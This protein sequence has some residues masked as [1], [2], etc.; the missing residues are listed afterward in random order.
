M[1]APDPRPTVTLIGWR[2]VLIAA[3]LGA[4]TGW[5]LFALPDRLGAQLPALP[6]V[7]TVTVVL[8]AAVCWVL[9]VR[10]HR[11]VQVRRES[12]EPSRAVTLLAFAKASVLTGALL[13][14][15]Y[16]AIGA[17][18]LQRWAAD[19]PRERVIS[20]A[21]AT[22]ASIALAVGGGFLERACRIPPSDDG[23]ATPNGLPGGPPNGD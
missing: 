8:L 19:L 1:A 14:G 23:D 17:Y 21:V 11:R 3:L 20:S 2:P 22:V 6:M 7:V 13:A 10:T 9:A 5:L 12:V 16:F 18:S 4:G 15:G